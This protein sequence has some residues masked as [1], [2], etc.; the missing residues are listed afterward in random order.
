MF[1]GDFLKDTNVYN[2]LAVLCIKGRVLIYNLIVDG[3][4]YRIIGKGLGSL[5]KGLEGDEV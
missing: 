2:F 3:G 5:S 4:V 1:Q